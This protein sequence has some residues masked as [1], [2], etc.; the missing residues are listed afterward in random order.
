MPAGEPREIHAIPRLRTREKRAAEVF[1]DCNGDWE[2]IGALEVY[3]TEALDYPFDAEWRHGERKQ[4]VAILRVA[5]DW[6]ED[7][8]IKF[9]AL[10][11]SRERQIPVAEVY[12][13]KPTGRIATVLENYR[14]WWPFDVE[15]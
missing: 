7:T 10:V 6:K 11:N 14:A 1:V 12:A 9:R 2:A 4:I 5:E 13:L 15:D 8:G 3:L